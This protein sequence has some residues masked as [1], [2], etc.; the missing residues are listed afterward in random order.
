MENKGMNE[1]SVSC[2]VSQ[3]KPV[4]QDSVHMQSVYS[5]T[6]QKL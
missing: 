4:E 3:V 6:F 5:H 1:W 2:V